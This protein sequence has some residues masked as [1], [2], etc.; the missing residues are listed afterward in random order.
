M[1][2]VVSLLDETHKALVQTVWSELEKLF[3]L[4]RVRE[5]PYPHFSYQVA[6]DYHLNI[7]DMTLTD[8]VT[9]LKPFTV[10][11]SDLDIFTRPQPVFYISVVRT[12]M[13][14][15]LQED[16]WTALLPASPEPVTYYHP[17]LWTPHITLALKDLDSD[18]LGELAR[19]LGTLDF[20]WE[21]EVDHLALIG[22]VDTGL[23]TKRFEFGAKHD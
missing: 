8:F 5:T 14:T 1:Y 6:E 16:L 7:L 19:F 11:T 23:E 12:A 13:L 22:N 2:S 17:N 18:T 9:S 21:I 4:K 10:T 20:S 3:G 15:K